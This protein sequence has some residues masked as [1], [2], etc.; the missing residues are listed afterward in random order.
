MI[1]LALLA[2]FSWAGDLRPSALATNIAA[3]AVNTAAI[4]TDAVT[5]NGILNG[6]VNTGKIGSGAVDTT[7]IKTD[8]VNNAAILNG[9][10]DTNKIASG[11]VDTTKIKNDSVRFQSLGTPYWHAVAASA[12]VNCRAS[13]GANNAAVGGGCDS[14][15]VALDESF[16]STETTDSVTTLGTA[17]S[18]SAKIAQSWSCSSAVTGTPTCYVL[19]VLK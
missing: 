7:K 15:A 11:S 17:V 14:G 1:L 6:S 4:S 8:A 10:V 16:P 3:G 5:T 9:S 19:C 12:A 18:D 13:C 2:S